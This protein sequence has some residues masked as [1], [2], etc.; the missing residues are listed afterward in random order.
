MKTSAFETDAEVFALVEA[1]ETS[2]IP[3]AEFSHV[4][5]IAVALSYLAEMP[6]EQALAR[7]RERI[8]AFAAHHQAEGLYHETLTTFWMKLLDHV[9]R[10]DVEAPLWRRI[11]LIVEQWG[12]RAPVEAH[13]SPE[14]LRSQTAR[15]D[16]V[17][18]DRLPL[19]F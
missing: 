16:Y 12:T 7:M 8:Q 14:L 17:A 15:Q 1:F 9:W 11:N 13:Y 4:A 2:A 10:I 18:P 3:A 6:R 19:P 5:H